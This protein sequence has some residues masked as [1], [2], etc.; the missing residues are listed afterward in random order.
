VVG[1]EGEG[2]EEED[3]WGREVGG[4]AAGWECLVR[5]AETEARA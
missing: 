3:G 5:K 2:E 4:A 1:G